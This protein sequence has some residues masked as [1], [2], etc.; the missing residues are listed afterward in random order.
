MPRSE[1]G[2]QSCPV[3]RSIDVVGDAWTLMV[4]RELF[5]GSRRF[6]DLQA[7]TGVSPH[8]LSLRMRKLHDA[9]VVER[10][11]YQERPFRYEYQLTAKGL[12]LWPLIMALRSWGDRWHDWPEGKPVKLRH[13][14]CG[15]RSEPRIV[16][17]SCGEAMGPRDVSI[18]VSKPAASARQAR[19]K[20]RADTA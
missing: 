6:D 5:L 10:Q 12:D 13:Q 11:A 3:A 1:I 14:A 7:Q 19:R 18:E 2:H 8:L 15:K 9:G 20:S 16:C 17:G 4:L